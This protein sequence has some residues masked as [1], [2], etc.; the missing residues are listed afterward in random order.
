MIVLQMTS[1]RSKIFFSG[2]LFRENLSRDSTIPFA[3]DA[4]LMMTESRFRSWGPRL[5]A[6]MRSAKPRIGVSLLLSSCAIPE[7]SSPSEVSFSVCMVFCS[8]R[9]LSVI[10]RRIIRI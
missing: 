2:G 6:S 7:V 5:S 4:A 3:A 9:L 10:S 8:M 1:R